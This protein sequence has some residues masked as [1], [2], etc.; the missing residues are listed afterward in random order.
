MNDFVLVE[1]ESAEC[2]QSDS[3]INFQYQICCSRRR[4]G[5]RIRVMETLN[6]K[7]RNFDL[8]TGDGVCDCY[9]AWPTDTRA[10]RA[11]IMY[12][13]AFGPREYLF[14]MCQTL[15]GRGFYVLLPNLFYRLKRAP[16]LD[17]EPYPISKDRIAAAFTRLREFL[18]KYNIEDGVRDGAAF[19]KFL[20]EQPDLSAT[21]D[22]AVT[23]YCMGGGVALRTA[24]AYPERISRVASFHAGRLVND[25]TSSPHRH[26]GD[27]KARI[28]IAHADNDGSMPAEAIKELDAA[29]ARAGV[30]YRAELY[31]GAA[32][33]FTM[34]DLPSYNEAALAR[35]WKKLFALLET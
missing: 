32:H 6:I 20:S 11:V 8:N 1:I 7:T 10:T 12:M 21:V 29:L 16:I 27:I 15:A 35:H 13:D 4:A 14:E 2:G 28:Y 25:S 24:A 34:K 30:E 19:L 23:G 31:Q 26:L 18:G 5:R 9:A 22:V 17:D 3:R 33:G